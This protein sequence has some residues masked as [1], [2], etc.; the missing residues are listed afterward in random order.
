[1]GW[2]LS[3]G[4]VRS[5]L[6]TT[7]CGDGEGLVFQSPLLS[8]QRGTQR[9]AVKCPK[10]KVSGSHRTWSEQRAR[11]ERVLSRNTRGSWLVS[12]DQ[13]HGIRGFKSQKLSPGHEKG[14]QLKPI[15][16]K[17]IKYLRVRQKSQGH[18]HECVITK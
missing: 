6:L 11:R 12:Y 5:P 7:V 10:L 3:P 1:M 2:L 14:A 16:R 9:E 8:N 17:R 18:R 13:C 4:A 15:A